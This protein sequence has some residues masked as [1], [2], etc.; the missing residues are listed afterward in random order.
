MR[1]TV[2]LSPIQTTWCVDSL[3]G[4]SK[5]KKR[6][7]TVFSHEDE[8]RR[9][10][11]GTPTRRDAALAPVLRELAELVRVRAVVPRGGE[12]DERDALRRGLLGRRREGEEGDELAH[13][14]G[15]VRLPG[16]AGG[17]ASA[18]EAVWARRDVLRQPWGDPRRVNCPCKEQCGRDLDVWQRRK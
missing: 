2:P 18:A 6:P 16:V 3:R 15:G 5:S 10:R 1:S 12:G 11:Q 17:Q 7:P 13:R 4:A 9:W 8:S 14:C